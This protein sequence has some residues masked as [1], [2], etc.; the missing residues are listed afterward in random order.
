MRDSMLEQRFDKGDHDFRAARIVLDADGPYDTVGVLLQQAYEK[1]IMGYLLSKGWELKKIH[2]LRELTLRAADYD[3]QFSE[4]LMTAR[5]L[6]AI[7]LEERYPVEGSQNISKNRQPPS[8]KKSKNS[9]HLSKN[10]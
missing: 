7:F 8:L 2:D 6:S 9:F 10:K 1:H 4:Y 5:R 3:P